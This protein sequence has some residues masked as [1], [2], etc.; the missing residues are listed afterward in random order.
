VHHTDSKNRRKALRQ[1]QKSRRPMGHSRLKQAPRAAPIIAARPQAQGRDADLAV[2]RELD[3]TG[4]GEA[5]HM[6][7]WAMSRRR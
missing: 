7:G 2:F 4:E 3:D 5:E 1:R 6:G